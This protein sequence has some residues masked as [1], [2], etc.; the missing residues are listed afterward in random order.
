ILGDAVDEVLKRTR[1]LSTEITPAVAIGVEVSHCMLTQLWRV[2][3]HPF[4][5]TQQCRLFAVPEAVHDRAL[6]MPALLEQLPEPARLLQL[7]ARPGER[8]ARAIDP[9]VMVIAANDPLVGKGGAG[10]RRDHIVQRLAVPVE[11][12]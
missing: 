5:R 6:W 2:C 10:N 3:L 4:G 12:N 8:I 11:A 7:R 1:A 9:G